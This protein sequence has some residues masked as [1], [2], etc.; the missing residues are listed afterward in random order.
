[1]GSILFEIT[2]KKAQFSSDL[3]DDVHLFMNLLNDLDME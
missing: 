3:F 1:M 2:T